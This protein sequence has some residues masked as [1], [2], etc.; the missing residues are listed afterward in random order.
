MGGADVCGFMLDTNEKLCSRWI[1]LG[2]LYPFFRNHNNDL[3]INQEFYT[4][5][6]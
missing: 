4:L 2:I 6:E 5:G 3:S 1:Q